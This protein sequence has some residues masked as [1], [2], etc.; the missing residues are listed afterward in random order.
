MTAVVSK[1]WQTTTDVTRWAEV[2]SIC[3]QAETRRVSA[4][5]D[6]GSITPL[7]ACL[8]W[9]L[10]D[11]IQARTVIEVGT[12]IGT[13]TS[14]L[15]SASTVKAVYT[16]DVS[17]D[18]LPGTH[19]IKVFPKQTSTEM[20]RQLSAQGVLADLCFFD[21]VLTREDIEL[22]ASV[23]HTNTV[24]ALHDHNYGPK[25]RKHGMEIMP[26]KGIGNAQ[27]LQAKWSWLHLVEPL[28]E[29]TL[30]ALVPEKWL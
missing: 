14:A 5:Y 30:A 23:C 29:T 11:D 24:F 26:R 27:L 9:A 21:G 7:E 25:I 6:T 3:A 19:V 10:A 13:S 20:L 15:A 18:C 1:L 8:L 16:C 12:F 4:D 17:N 22:L 2:H 28:P